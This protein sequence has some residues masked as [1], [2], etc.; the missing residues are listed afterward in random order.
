M[1]LKVDLSKVYEFILTLCVIVPYF[2]N[3]EL[4]I[5]IWSFAVLISINKRYSLGI[6]YQILCFSGILL[7]AL[8]VSF[9]R[10]NQIYYCVRDITYLIK[11]ILGLLIGYQLSKKTRRNIFELIIYI[12]LIF[13]L[14][15][16]FFLIKSVLMYK[17]LNINDLRL[18]GGYF[19]DFEVFSLIIAFFH[20]RFNICISK[21]RINL[22]ILIIS[23]SVFFYLARTNFIQLIILFLSLKGFFI[24]NKRNMMI[25]GLFTA[26][27]ILTYSIILVLNPKRNGPGMEAFLYKIK[28]IPEEAFKTKVNRENWK[29][30][31]D[32]YRSYEN[33]IT[34]QK[35]KKNELNSLFFGFGLGSKVDLKQEMLLG[36]MKLR[37]ISILHNGYMTVLLKS[38]IMGLVLLLVS[39][40]VYF[41]KVD[42]D[43][44]IVNNT[45]LLLLGMGIFMIM[46]YWVFMGFYFKADNKSILL[47]M[48]IYYREILISS[49][50]KINN[51][52]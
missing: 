35:I 29:Q 10:D 11:P 33:V 52:D 44:T 14:V 16:I 42:S 26:F 25:L 19:S 40:R 46:S 48:L 22:F 37:Y 7:I 3:F 27:I 15:H 1:T 47:G 30:M 17:V 23:L 32:N 41:M 20:K 4:T 51:N 31:N 12:G 45:N 13:S 39:F 34:I 24:V 49:K 8:V 28:I 9:Y 50:N 21:N 6:I 5:S 38:G 36:D 43:H 2:D 18:F